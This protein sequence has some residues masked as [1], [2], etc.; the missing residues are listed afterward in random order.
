MQISTR[1]PNLARLFW[2]CPQDCN[3]GHV[4][5]PRKRQIFNREHLILSVCL[6]FVFSGTQAKT[7]LRTHFFTNNSKW[8]LW[9]VSYC[10]TEEFIKHEN[11]FNRKVFHDRENSE[12]QFLEFSHFIKGFKKY[13]MSISRYFTHSVSSPLKISY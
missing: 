12:N 2:V 13:I 8:L 4:N 5:I 3:P 7:H 11:K 1:I 10:K 9:N 6:D